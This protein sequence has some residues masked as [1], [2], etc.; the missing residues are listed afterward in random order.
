M[1][2]EKLDNN[3][4]GIVFVDNKIT[5]VKNAL[6]NEEVQIKII[7]SKKK[8]QEAIVLNYEKISN[9]RVNPICPYYEECGGCDLMHLN[10]EKQKE[11][12]LK[13]VK[14]LL[15]KFSKID[16]NIKQ[17]EVPINL[18]Y[19]NKATFQ[20][21]ENIGYYKEK[22]YDLIP[23]DKCYIVDNKINE[24]LDKVKKMNLSNIYQI[25]IRASKNTN[26]TMVVFKKNKDIKIDISSLDVTSIIEY[27]DNKYNTLKGNDYILEKLDD[28]SFII[29]PDSFFQVNTK[30]AEALYKKVLDYCDLSGN[31]FVLDLYCGTG[32]IG[33]FL[34]K[35]ASNVIG[36]EINHYAVEDAIKN[37]KLNRISNIEFYCDDASNIKFS[38]IDVVVVDPPRSGLSKEM[39]DYLLSIKSK[40]IVYVSCDP[41]TLSRDLNILKNE[42]DIKDISLVDMFPNTHH[43]E[44]V[45][46]MNNKYL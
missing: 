41:V 9:D 3:G 22:S 30:G 12:K 25:V 23:I 39:I 37:K 32:T 19:R 45:C 29:S 18:N 4:R 14:D 38:N 8:Y 27:Y 11:F 43:V 26:D 42:Y 24:I 17:I 1:R 16:F 33:L 13:K 15:Y 6:P 34:S 36:V 21:K 5:F 40:K 28:M 44:T 46:V 31:E 7:N 35:K 20:V 10:L 2:I